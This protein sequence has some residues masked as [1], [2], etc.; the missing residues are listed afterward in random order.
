MI[1]QF[2]LR[3]G[4]MYRP[5]IHWYDQDGM[6]RSVYA[7]QGR[8]SNGVWYFRNVG[9]YRQDNS[10]SRSML[11][12]RLTN[13]LALPMLTETPEQIRSE[14]WVSERLSN[15]RGTKEADVP[16]A[17]VLDYLRLHPD[18][19]ERVAP[20]IRTMMHSRLA[21]P[22]TCLVVVLIAVPFAGATGRKD[23]FVGVA[24]SIAICFAYFVLERLGIALGVGGYLPPVLAAWLP[25]AL[26]STAA[27]AMIL[28][29]R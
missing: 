5:Q 15:I 4:K 12:V 2:D 28:R 19:D 11:P 22:W 18:P 23:M 25:N 20:W 16:L 26:F 21:S 29:I 14:I 6:L 13:Q 3:T 7:E 24:S 17:I 10:G 27:I 9:E 8:H 1:E